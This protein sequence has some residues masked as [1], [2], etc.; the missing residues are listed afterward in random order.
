M[1]RPVSCAV[2]LILG[3]CRAYAQSPQQIEFFEKNIRPLLAEKCYACHSA[4]TMAM[5]EL[6]LDSQAA[7]RK[8]GSRGAAIAPSDPEG[9][10]LIRA[11]RY[12]S[13]DL[14]MPPTGKLA[15]DEIADLEAWVRM[16][17]PDPRA[18]E[19]TPQAREEKIDMQSGREF[20]SFQPVRDP[21]PPAVRNPAWARSD[22]DRFILA[23]LEAQRLRPA[24]EADRRT[25]LRR[26]TFD[27]TGLPPTPEE[28]EAFLSDPSPRAY[29]KVVE[30]LLASPHYGERWGRHWLD[31]VR[32]AE[33]NGHEFDNNKLDAWRYRD[34]VI[35]AFNSDLPYNRF[36][37]EQ[38]A[39]DLMPQRLAADGTYAVN[40]IASGVFWL[41]EVLNS[42]T[43]SV[44]ARADQID[45]QIDVMT[46]AAQGLTV[47][48]A[49]CHDHKFDP[50]PTEDYYSLFGI[51][52]STHMNEKCIDSPQ[53]A[54]RI[55]SVNR[56]IGD[57]QKDVR[58]HLQPALKRLAA[59]V[60]ER[61]LA[62]APKIV[63]TDARPGKRVGACPVPSAP[64]PEDAPKT[65][66]EDTESRAPVAPFSKQ[67][68]A[69]ADAAPESPEGMDAEINYA[70]TEPS[71]P[72]FLFA[73]VTEPGSADFAGRLDH[74]RREMREWAAKAD[75]KHPLWAERGDVVYE[76]FESGYS[77]WQVS[78]AAFGAEPARMVPPNLNLAGYAGQA[79]ASS[80][81][82]GADALLGTLTTE[83]FRMPA[84]FVHVRMAGPQYSPKDKE[85]AK[86][87]FTVI[88]DEHKSGH[89]MADGSGRLQWKTIAM[90]KEYGR[91][92]Y[93]EIVDRDRRGSAAVERIVFS[94]NCAPPPIAGK[95]DERIL[96]F[97]ERD[98]I[99]SLEDLARAYQG[100]AQDL[101]AAKN[102]TP[103]DE[104]LLASLLGLRRLED[105]A[106]ALDE[107]ETRWVEELFS[108][109]DRAAENIPPS[110]F[111]MTSMDYEPADSPIHVR[112]NHK[113]PGAIAP[114]RFL[115]AVSGSDRKPFAN[116]SG[117]LELA[118]RIAGSENPL[119][120]RVMVN[121]VW[122][123][124]FGKG[125]VAT[126]D[127][128]GKTGA[129][130]THPDLLDRLA[131]RFMKNGWSIKD[132]QRAIVFSS[133]YRQSSA[134]SAKT[135]KSDPANRWLSYMPVR[136]L[137]AEAIRDSVLAVAGTLNRKVGGPSVMPHISEFQ[138][139]R[140]KPKPGGPLDG[141]GRRSIYIQVRRNFLTPLL[142]AFDYPLPISTIGRRGVSAV[143]S[144][145]L[146]L[147]NNEFVNT[148]AAHW[149][150]REI[151]THS[152]AKDRIDDMYVR[153]FGREP[154]QKEVARI[155]RFLAEQGRARGVSGDDDPQ[156]WTD[157]AHALLN[158]S[159]FI[160]IR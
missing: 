135:Q 134:A 39:G 100:L 147:L 79:L 95:P 156:V 110:T 50:I 76:D 58:S 83:K 66:A 36:L 16:G 115:Q 74:M 111:A 70:L 6:R 87:R 129:R 88:A 49:R 18:G 84:R 22:I 9:S 53:R 150:Q 61:Y 73:R 24:P 90:T 46:K 20:W 1:V 25:L 127:N 138:D 92:C 56:M 86:V 91:I 109:R 52:Q 155:R 89:A 30:R 160:F 158:T 40:P 44:K 151:E 54:A 37:K 85:D 99:Q 137:E 136:R 59:T 65:V 98:D 159:E 34:Y 14:R 48:C 121:R 96:A 133:A 113:N 7:V 119:T 140:G 124:H 141:M 64:E 23:K 154:L 139:G 118:E 3:L 45:N 75:R 149:A 126:P 103:A 128:F 131:T 55:Q 81:G 102:R 93:L 130:P 42:P 148:Q 80:F 120:A 41:W 33:T 67:P 13:L 157:L 31:L 51:F 8:G 94:K 71:H 112:G 123:H 108:Y 26:V 69:Q 2:L 97:L 144:Q 10:L 21:A 116:G 114:R 27:L 77:R 107:I 4:D 117:R 78:G 19:R 38:I 17:A 125:I 106:S 82:N 62:A 32:W 47:A 132:L 11:V 153:A 143:P 12:R 146:T 105:A 152:R 104:A 28:I 145:A 29:E 57:I 5:G 43:D 101:A 15:D 72:L 63:S 35:D 68:A 122:K 142:L 60:A